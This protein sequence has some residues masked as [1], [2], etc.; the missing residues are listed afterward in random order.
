MLSEPQLI[1]RLW[2]AKSFDSNESC[3]IYSTLCS[4]FSWN[5]LFD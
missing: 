2:C 3:R 1:A 4:T 5:N